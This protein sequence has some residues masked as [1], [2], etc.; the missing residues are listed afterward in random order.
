MT[1]EKNIQKILVFKP[2]SLGDILHVFPALQI[3]HDNYP[4]AGLDFVVNPEFAPLLDFSP[5][6]VRRRILFERTKL[7]ALTTAP[8]EFFSLIKNT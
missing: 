1:K 5:F 8:R 2:S 4:D 6:P 3:L 7:A